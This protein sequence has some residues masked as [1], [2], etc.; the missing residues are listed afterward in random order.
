V[1]WWRRR[2]ETLN[3]Q[4]MRE[5]G[6]DPVTG[7]EVD[8]LRPSDALLPRAI[9]GWS[10]SPAPDWEAHTTASAPDLTGDAYEFAIE[11]DGALIVPD[12]CDENLSPLADAAETVVPRPCRV[13]AARQEGDS[14]SISVRRIQVAELAL[15]TGDTIEISNV[16]GERNAKID[17]APAPYDV[18][19]SAL[20]RIG[21]AEGPDYVI[22][23]TRL[24]DRL[25]EV[26][27]SPL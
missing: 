11:P 15:A 1:S 9:R 23:A 26:V 25:W 5:A 19:L 16:A 14:W 4:L 12:D 2:N 17:G 7:A 18:D 3:E 10:D 8:A 21:A 22:Q 24:D 6:M 20:D 13:A 27:A